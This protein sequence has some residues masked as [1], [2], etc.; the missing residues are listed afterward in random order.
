MFNLLQTITEALA[1]AQSPAVLCSFGSDSTLLLHFARQVRPDIAVYYFGDTLPEL[2]R[3]MVLRNDLTI[4]S[5]APADRYLVPVGE[6]VVLVDEYAVNGVRVP[7]V[8][9]VKTNA[10]TNMQQDGMQ[11]TAREPNNEILSQAPRGV[12]ARSTS[13]C[14]AGATSEGQCA[15]QGEGLSET[16]ATG[17][18]SMR[19]VRDDGESG[20][21]PHRLRLST[22]SGLDV[23]SMS[24]ER[25]QVTNVENCT[26]HAKVQ[27]RTTSFYFPHDT[28]LWG[29]RRED[30]IEL[31]NATFAREV[32]IN[33]TKF[34]APLYDLTTDQVLNALDALGLDY[35]TD[36]AVEFC[37]ECLNM[38]INSNWDR[39]A[40]LA[41]FRSRFNYSH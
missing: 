37:D 11:R 24:P 30:C 34:I 25:A 22:N 3:Q 29:Y 38:I 41:G 13:S 36:D 14:N 12:H 7:M 39:D 10:K 6:R 2:A 23:P 1:P 35:V 21:A 28:V 15:R 20:N 33:H 31:I 4:Y 9:K 40:A 26:G 16:R 5:Y 18:S 8:S 32:Q 27:P 17:T 19:S